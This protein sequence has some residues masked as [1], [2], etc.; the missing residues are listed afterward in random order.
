MP[1]TITRKAGNAITITTPDGDI[2][3]TVRRIE[4]RQVRL[5]IDAPKHLTILRD[6]LKP[7]RATDGRADGPQTPIG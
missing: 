2:K 5:S 1:L 7:A 6:E 3:I 4:K